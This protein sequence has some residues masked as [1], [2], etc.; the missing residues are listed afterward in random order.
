MQLL[1]FCRTIFVLH[2]NPSKKCYQLNIDILGMSPKK[3]FEKPIYFYSNLLV[4]YIR[5]Q[6]FLPLFI[7]DAQGT[8][9][10]F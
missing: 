1:G 3:L 6:I 4:S 7:R 10:G 5:Q 8:R 9:P 2:S